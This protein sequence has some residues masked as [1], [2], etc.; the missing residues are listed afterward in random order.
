[1]H[2]GNNDNICLGA[3]RLDVIKQL[4]TFFAKSDT[5]L[6]NVKQF[7]KASGLLMKELTGTELTLALNNFSSSDVVTQNETMK[8]IYQ[9]LHQM[10][11]RRARLTPNCDLSATVLVHES[12]LKLFTTDKAWTDR[13][14]FSAVAATAM[15][16]ISI[17]YIR[18][19]V[20]QK[21]GGSHMAVTY[22]EELVQSNQDDEL[23]L[24]V[25]EIIE[26]LRETDPDIVTLIELKFFI[27]LTNAEVAEAT[28]KSLRT[29][30][31]QWDKAKQMIKDAY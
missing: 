13:K 10:A 23:I 17:D 16:Q 9:A 4:H 7:D 30:N 8:K 28:D 27:G 21:R 26:E 3:D 15:R 24:K 25:H 11:I 1:M 5:L 6:I 29:V 22:S 14:H 20:A 12:F 19:S 18:S 31:R 2:V